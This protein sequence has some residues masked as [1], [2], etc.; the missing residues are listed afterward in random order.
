MTNTPMPRSLGA[1]QR[2]EL[3]TLRVSDEIATCH[4]VSDSVLYESPNWT[5]D[6]LALVL[7][8]DGVLWR[9]DLAVGTFEHIPIDGV[10]ALNNDH[11][12]AP[13]GRHV[14]VSANDWHIYRAPTSGGVAERITGC[15]G[16]EGLMH[17]LHGVDPDDERLAFI[18]LQSEGDDWWA[19]AD[20]FTMSTRGADYRRLT[21]GPG[22][23][24]GSEFSPDGEWLYFNSDMFDGHAQI[25]RMRPDGSD[26]EQ[27]T[28]D[29]RVNWFPHLSPDGHTVVYISF[30]PST[31][32]HP[33]DL[34][35]ELKAVRDHD[36]PGAAVAH[37]F[38]GQGSMNVNSWSPNS[39][40][41]AYV[42]YPRGAEATT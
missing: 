42:A 25:A 39:A 27:L 10:P 1:G 3:W 32:R 2:C 15:S 23:S 7:N 6:G 34:N 28:H 11:V 12:L 38:G 4:A 20:V 16:I 41:F 17:F 21:G 36:W 13:D 30:P 5:R 8:G 19:R 22:A 24:D 18:G 29:H 26:L 9:Y 31:K 40:E 33:S 14:Y 35:V 37:I